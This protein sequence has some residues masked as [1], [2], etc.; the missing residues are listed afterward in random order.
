MNSKETR[1]SVMNSATIIAIKVY[2]FLDISIRFFL[3]FTPLPILSSRFAD[4]PCVWREFF[5]VLD[6]T[7]YQG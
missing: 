3:F 6:L 7:Q 5:F 2:K 1:A 4:G